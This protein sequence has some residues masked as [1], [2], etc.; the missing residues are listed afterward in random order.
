[1]LVQRTHLQTVLAAMPLS[2]CPKTVLIPS[3]LK[4]NIN[5]SENII[6]WD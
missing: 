1:M 4:S 5:S 3:S 2:W 6:S